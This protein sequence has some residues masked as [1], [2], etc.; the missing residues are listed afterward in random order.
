MNNWPVTNEQQQINDGWYAMLPKK[1]AMSPQS[2]Q[3]FLFPI[4]HLLHK[5]STLKPALFYILQPNITKND[6]K[7]FTPTTTPYYTSYHFLCEGF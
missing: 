6:M 2:M 5:I 3:Q 1:L 4:S 7:K